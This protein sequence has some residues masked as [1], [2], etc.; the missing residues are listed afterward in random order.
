MP[1]HPRRRAPFAALAALAIAT[2]P[3]VPQASARESADLPS[4]RAGGDTVATQAGTSVDATDGLGTEAT[5]R[6]GSRTRVASAQVWGAAIPDAG[7]IAAGRLDFSDGSQLSVGAVPHDGVHPSTVA[8]APRSVDWVRFTVT[9][10]TGRGPASIEE[11]RVLPVGRTPARTLAPRPAPLAAAYTGASVPTCTLRHITALTELCPPAGATVRGDTTL[12]IAAHGAPHVDVRVISAES[13]VAP[14]VSRA[15]VRDGIATVR[16]G[17]SALPPGPFTVRVDAVQNGRPAVRHIQLVH[18]G[19]SPS[20]LAGVGTSGAASGM[21][22]AF[23]EEFTRPLSI[24]RLG[25]GTGAAYASS[26]PEWY[27]AQEF[28]DAIF[29]D[30]SQGLDNMAVVGGD[31]LR[32]TLSPKPA[33]FADTMGW[34]RSY[35]G[36]MLSSMAP[37]GSGFAAQYGFFEARVLTP[38]ATGAWPSFWMLPADSA[39]GEQTTNA[40]IDIMEHYGHDPENVCHATHRWDRGRDAPAVR[41]VR[42]Y[43]S[44]DAALQWHTYGVK[45]GRTE[46]V[47]YVDGRETARM[48]QIAGGDEPM[49]FMMNMGAGGNWPIDLATASGSASM[50][51]DWIR[52]YT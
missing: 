27:G 15:P 51:V 29:A 32:I 45:V 8:F 44:A 23:E 20:Q 4:L 11:F 36:G 9:R 1:R 47:Y 52:V 35:V 39:A 19:G 42:P 49:Y 17:S 40:E 7:T 2:G 31:V 46:I 22:L 13:R 10:T 5:V 28:A 18:G 14:T 25:T 38:A 48:P 30:P 34:S 3:V 24:S 12:T 43:A 33:G 16:I 6:F 21:T 41:C 50:F 26:K 37:G